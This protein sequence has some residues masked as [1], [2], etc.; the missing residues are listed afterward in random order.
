M[1][2]RIIPLFQNGVISIDVW[3]DGK[4]VIYIGTHK[5]NPIIITCIRMLRGLNIM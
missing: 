2:F 5:N 3:R 1:T 4:L